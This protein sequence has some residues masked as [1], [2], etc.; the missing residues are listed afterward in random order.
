MLKMFS[1]FSG[2]D[3]AIADV[4]TV[5][6]EGAKSLNKSFTGT[7]NMILRICATRPI[8]F[9]RAIVLKDIGA[10]KNKKTLS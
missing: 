7:L 10:C 8:I 6:T 3:E 4:F 5:V 2:P 9:F 1:T